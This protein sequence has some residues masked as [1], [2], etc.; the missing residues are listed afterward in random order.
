MYTLEDVII[1][2]ILVNYC[3]LSLDDKTFEDLKVLT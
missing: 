3:V 2:F 1:Q